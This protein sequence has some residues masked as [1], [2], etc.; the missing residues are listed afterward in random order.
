MGMRFK[1]EQI[2]RLREDLGLTQYDFGKKILQPPQV[3]SAYERGKM[4]PSLKVLTRMIERFGK[5]FDYF[6]VN[7]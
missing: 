7:E 1:P 2:K 4:T 6:F 5:S 3:I